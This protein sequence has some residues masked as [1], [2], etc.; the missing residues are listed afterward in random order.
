MVIGR[1][2]VGRRLPVFAR[3]AAD[4]PAAAQSLER[5]APGTVAWDHVAMLVEEVVE[6]VKQTQDV[7]TVSIKLSL[8]DIVDDHVPDFFRAA[9]NAQ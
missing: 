2:L 7:L 9:L 1:V 5:G 3:D 6:Y 4:E 8:P